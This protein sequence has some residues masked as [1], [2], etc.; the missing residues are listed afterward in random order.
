[1]VSTGGVN[2]EIPLPPG[3]LD[4]TDTA[5]EWLETAR[6][7]SPP[8]NR[9][10]AMLVPCE[11]TRLPGW[12]SL[13]IEEIKRGISI[14]V[15]RSLEYEL[16]SVPMF[17]RIMQEF[18][19]KP[20]GLPPSQRVLLKRQ[21]AEESLREGIQI[22]CLFEE[23]RSEVRRAGRRGAVLTMMYP[24]SVTDPSSPDDAPLKIWQGGVT[25]AVQTRQKVLYISFALEQ[26]E[27]RDRAEQLAR[28]FLT[29]MTGWQPKSSA[30]MLV[31]PWDA[32]GPAVA[33]N[34]PADLRP[35]NWSTID[36]E[37]FG[38]IRIPP[39]LEIQH[40]QQAEV[41]KQLNKRIGKSNPQESRLV[42]QP[43]GMSRFE[44]QAL[45][46][47]FRLIIESEPEQE[48]D[49]L[50]LNELRQAGPL[51]LALVGQQLKSEISQVMG[52]SLLEMSPVEIK[53][54]DRRPALYWW[55]RRRSTVATRPP[56]V[57]HN[58]RVSS[59]ARMHR[60]QVAWRV[61]ETDRWGKLLPDLVAGMRIVD[62]PLKPA[63]PL[64]AG[65]GEPED[66]E[67]YKRRARRIFESMT[68]NDR[69]KLPKRDRAFLKFHEGLTAEALSATVK[70]ANVSNRLDE[71]ALRLYGE[72]IE[73]DPTLAEAYVARGCILLNNHSEHA[74]AIA[75]H[76]RAIQ[77]K[78][79]YAKAY[80]HRA[81]TYS[82]D[83]DSEKTMRDLN[84]AIRLD[85]NF[86]AA[87]SMR[88]ACYKSRK[89]LDLYR[90]DLQKARELKYEST[91]SY[92]KFLSP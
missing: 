11:T 21:Y 17:D 5:V 82:D 32:N 63:R 22:R 51:A 34:T 78:P 3:H 46:W 57:V 2:I 16:I 28:W 40:G 14:H 44:P 87:Y 92:P 89:Q 75:D 25:V 10:L 13:P 70:D 61:T 90:R 71:R 23:T 66:L 39:H 54:I 80:Y 15:V 55:I 26:A 62:S 9:V 33:S 27:D 64:A 20:P 52:K 84:Q 73:I 65:A 24:V 35:T 86:G 12:P 48:S 43:R 58:Y 47:Y 6:R 60:I 19:K 8:G 29:S 74:K 85:P 59:D 31:P 56:V 38:T 50:D 76:T 81:D 45:R 41:M 42:V 91:N 68:S 7:L 30:Q 69:S 36:V 83:G 88:A 37:Q 79:N 67:E 72:A 53:T 4:V 1:M 18:Q 49:K 77:L